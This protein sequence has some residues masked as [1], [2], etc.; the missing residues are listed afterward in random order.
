MLKVLVILANGFEDIEAMTIIDILRRGDIE[1]TVAGLDSLEI[2]SAHNM[3]LSVTETLANNLDKIFDAVILP[4]GEPGTT[5]LENSVDVEAIIKRHD[6]Q[7]KLI[8][9]ICAAPRILDK[10]GIVSGKKA[11]SYPAFKEVMT[12]CNYSEEPVVV[13][14]NIITSRGPA[15]AHQFAFAIVEILHSTTKVKELKEAM[16]YS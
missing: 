7:G 9:A 14:E 15:T 2:T 16:L 1:V 8:A 12:S 5:H 11:T 6:S 3:T 4:G 13:D 10:I